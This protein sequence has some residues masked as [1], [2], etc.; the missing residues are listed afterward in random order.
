MADF[1]TDHAECVTVL[2]LLETVQ[3]LSGHIRRDS[4]CDSTW[5]C[6]TLEL[7]PVANVFVGNIITWQLANKHDKETAL[8]VHFFLH[9]L[10]I[11][12]K[13]TQVRHRTQATCLSAVKSDA[14]SLACCQ[15]CAFQA[16][17]VG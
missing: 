5:T 16:A 9:R 13:N 3:D 7:S 17:A 12:L 6:L 4:E 10:F 1:C 11:R 14:V 2:G 8:A 15:R